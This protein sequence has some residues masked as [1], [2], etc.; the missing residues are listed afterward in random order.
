MIPLTETSQR[1]PID[2]SDTAI[3][4]PAAPMPPKT[5]RNG[6]IRGSAEDDVHKLIKADQD[7]EAIPFHFKPLSA[8]IPLDAGR[9]G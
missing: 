2:G 7:I 6:F 9:P 3:D 4:E 8:T 1:D 5:R